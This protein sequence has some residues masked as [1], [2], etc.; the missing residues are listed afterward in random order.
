MR[1]LPKSLLAL[2][3]IVGFSIPLVSSVAGASKTKSFPVTLKLADGTFT[4][5]SRPDAIV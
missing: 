2:L 1:S 4:F 3:V 5:T